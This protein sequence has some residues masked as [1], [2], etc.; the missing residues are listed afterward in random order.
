MYATTKVLNDTTT[1]NVIM[2]F[3]DSSKSAPL[4]RV[5]DDLFASKSSKTRGSSTGMSDGDNRDDEIAALIRRIEQSDKDATEAAKFRVNTTVKTKDGRIVIIRGAPRVFPIWYTSTGDVYSDWSILP[6]GLKLQA[7]L[8]ELYER[9]RYIDYLEIVKRL[10]DDASAEINGSTAAA[11]KD[12]NDETGLRGKGWELNDSPPK[13]SQSAAVPS[14][15][16]SLKASE[17][18]RM[19]PSRSE[20]GKSTN[21]KTTLNSLSL[22]T[23]LILWR[24]FVLTANAMAG[25]AIQN[26]KVDLSQQIL[27]LGVTCLGRDDLFPLDIR[28]ELQAYMNESNAYFFFRKKSYGAALALV[29]KAIQEFESRG[30]AFAKHLAASILHHGC[31]EAQ[32]GHHKEAH[33]VLNFPFCN[34]LA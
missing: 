19:S 22:D 16:G 11:V 20:V 1:S 13:M 3:V 34:Y 5:K 29:H 7:H 26:K 4:D 2:D 15:P 32:M 18:Y 17:T 9:G 6:G 14:S 12:T 33:K 27:R 24:Q 10:L 8:K 23:L 28:K 25:I 31:I 21:D 30:A